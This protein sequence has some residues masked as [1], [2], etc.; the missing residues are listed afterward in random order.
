MQVE[1]YEGNL[2]IVGARVK[3]AAEPCRPR[4]MWLLDS[5][6]GGHRKTIRQLILNGNLEGVT[7]SLFRT[8]NRDGF[9]GTQLAPIPVDK[10]D[11]ASHTSAWVDITQMPHEDV[12]LTTLGL[13]SGKMD[14]L[15]SGW[16]LTVEEWPGMSGPLGMLIEFDWELT[17]KRGW[18]L[19]SW[20][21]FREH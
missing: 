4:T 1:P 16:I 10:R 20:V 2:Y 3:Q 8:V 15:P 6:I 11:S 17:S 18:N 19:T 12:H 14:I 7:A 21:T 5:G 13:P 9:A